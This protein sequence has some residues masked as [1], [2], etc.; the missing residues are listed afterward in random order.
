LQIAANLLQDIP[1]LDT[2]IENGAMLCLIKI[3]KIRGRK[4]MGGEK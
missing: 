3:E 4:H 1:D 2:V